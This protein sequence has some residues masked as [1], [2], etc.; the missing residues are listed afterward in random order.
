MMKWN[1]A[2]IALLLS[3]CSS[4]SEVSYYQLPPVAAQSNNAQAVH[5]SA[6]KQLWI[7]SVTVADFL[8]GPGIAFQTSDVKYTV[9]KNNLWGS[10]LDQQLKQALTDNL[11]VLLPGRV[12]SGQLVSGHDADVLRVTVTGFQGRYDGYA[13]VSGYWMLQSDN[14]IIRRPFNIEAPLQKDGYDELVYSLANAWHKESVDIA[15]ALKN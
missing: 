1:I 11:S 15:N 13:I 6:G 2:V 9:A 3:A 4:Q 14:K 12:V 8:S 7:E 5:L 10:S